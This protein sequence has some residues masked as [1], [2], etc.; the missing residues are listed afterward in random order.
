MPHTESL[1]QVG[2]TRSG[3]PGCPERRIGRSPDP[4][5]I[6][7]QLAP[8]LQWSGEAVTDGRRWRLAVRTA[9]FDVWLIAW[10]QGGRV[11]L[12]DH[13]R[14]RG[15]IAV[16][17][18][19]LVE[20][21]PWRD[22]TG[23]FALHRRTLAV[24]D[25]VSFGSHHVHD[26]VNDAQEHAVSLHVYSPPLRTMGFYEV[27]LGGLAA[28]DVRDVRDVRDGCEDGAGAVEVPTPDLRAA[29]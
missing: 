5:E 2:R 29:G 22:D 6:A 16:L 13:G 17:E 10:P 4:L 8:V 20:A 21:T 28:R 26:V 19:S 11:E 24:G 18:G 12:H 14:S 9:Q 3:L 27:T 23:R 15:A 1:E 25:V 7:R